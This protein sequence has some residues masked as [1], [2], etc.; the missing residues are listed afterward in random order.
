MY[1]L[2]IPSISTSMIRAC[3]NHADVALPEGWGWVG[4]WFISP[5]RQEVDEEA[6]MNS[7]VEC[8]FENER[9]YPLRGWSTKVR[10]TFYFCAF[11][12]C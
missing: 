2:P 10:P 1:S 8:V 9:Y 6:S 12:V 3:C 11:Y 4:D 5:E 7:V